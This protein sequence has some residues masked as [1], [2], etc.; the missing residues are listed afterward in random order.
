MAIGRKLRGLFGD[1]AL[2]LTVIGL[3]IYGIA[4]V[5]SAGVLDAPKPGVANAWRMQVVWFIIS[6]VAM[7]IV[8]RVQVRWIEWLALPLYII[9]VIALVA[10]LIIG[11]GAGTAEG[12]K[13]WLRFGPAA[14][15]PS[16]FANVAT[17]LMVAKIMGSWRRPRCSAC[18]SRCWS[19]SSPW[20]WSSCSPTS[21]R[22]WSSAAS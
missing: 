7:F 6:L 19:S 21:A 16:Q 17:I 15:Q 5:Y 12:T 2:A 1:P 13:S 11:T 14:V 9:G 8:S 20:R 10:T 3:T 22:R 18:G 4:M